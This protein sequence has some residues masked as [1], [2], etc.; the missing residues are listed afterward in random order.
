M[1]PREIALQVIQ[2]QQGGEAPRLPVALLSGGTW[3]FHQR[4]LSLKDVLDDPRRA[5]Q[6][7]SDVNREVQSDIVWPGSGY[8]NLLIHIFGGK[9]K[10]REQGNIDVCAPAFHTLGETEK[11]DLAAIDNHEWI[12]AIRDIIAS[13]HRQ[14]GEQYLIGTSG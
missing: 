5:P 6:V 3:T 8:H 1:N 14:I 11:I 12:A 9:I 2:P 4:N 10:F 13:V 7:I